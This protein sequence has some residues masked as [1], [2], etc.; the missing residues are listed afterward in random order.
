MTFL[1]VEKLLTEY[2]NSECLWG[3]EPN[4][5]VVRI[6]E[7]IK[8]GKILDIGAGEGR[9]SLYLAQK[10]FDVTGVDISKEAIDKLLNF[11]KK[12]KL[13]I[14]G[15]VKSITD[16][17]FNEQYDAI[18]S[19]ATLHLINKDDL[20]ELI[21]KMKKKT[22]KNGLNL[23]TVFTDKDAGREQFPDLYFFNENEIR[24][25]Y[26]DWEIIE[27]TTYNKEESHGKPHI[28]NICVLIARK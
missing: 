15:I 23:L 13:N 10:G 7:L 4:K 5:Y 18:I 16:F 25:I 21:N 3:L 20:F 22:K 28:H 1:N 14:N 11:S 24:D 6:P 17:E 27:H 19:V 12:N 9:N 26:N 8:S 2:V